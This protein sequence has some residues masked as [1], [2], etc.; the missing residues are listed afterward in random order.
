MEI[1]SFELVE[2]LK[3]LDNVKP[4]T[5][6]NTHTYMYTHRR[7]RRRGEGGRGG[8]GGEEREREIAPRK[9]DIHMYCEHTC[10]MM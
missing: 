9:I 2:I 10:I 5:P 7:E 1:G 8:R 6:A 3:I 4:D